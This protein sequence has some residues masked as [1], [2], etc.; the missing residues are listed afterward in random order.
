MQSKTRIWSLR[1]SRQAVSSSPGE[2][3][4][5]LGDLKVRTKVRMS[6]F[7]EPGRSIRAKKV[8]ASPKWRAQVNTSWYEPSIFR[9][10]RGVS[11]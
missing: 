11:W 6:S 1:S 8:F 5:R 4:A 7:A 10:V 2:P 9:D 3:T